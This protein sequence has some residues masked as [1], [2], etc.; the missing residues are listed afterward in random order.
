MIDCFAESVRGRIK[1][2]PGPP[3]CQEKPEELRRTQ[4]NPGAK[5][6]HAI[7]NPTTTGN[8]KTPP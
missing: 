4:E 7:V 1:A 6:T 5:I 2:K 3:E 8:R